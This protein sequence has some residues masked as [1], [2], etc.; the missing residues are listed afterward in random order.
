MEVCKGY[1]LAG[2]RQAIQQAIDGLMRDYAGNPGLG[3]ELCKV[4]N[5]Y[6]EAY[7]LD[8]NDKA[9]AG[10]IDKARALYRYVLEGASDL[11][12]AG[13][14]AKAGLIRLD[15]IM[16]T[17]EDVFNQVDSIAVKYSP[18]AL[19]ADLWETVFAQYYQKAIETGRQG[20]RDKA[21]VYLTKAALAMEKVAG[22]CPDKRP[23]AYYAL[24][25]CYHRLGD[26]RKAIMYCQR[27][28]QGWPDYGNAWRVWVL[29]G[30]CWSELGGMGEVSQ[31]AVAI[32][33]R[34]VCANLARYSNIPGTR[35]VRDIL[36]RKNTR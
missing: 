35:I 4:A 13:L 24:A 2:D 15:I 18:E 29:I 25:C 17:D 16:E 11:D 33:T 1:I 19:Q 31:S 22:S 20:K 9:K 21:S 30:L 5:T 32:G 6:L 34:D 7:T 26:P 12:T 3:I 8:P 23:D 10:Y 27:V 28:L 36:C 14:W